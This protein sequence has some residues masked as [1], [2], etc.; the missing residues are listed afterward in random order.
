MKLPRRHVLPPISEKEFQA[1]V[2]ELARLFGFRVYH[3][4]DSRRSAK[5]FPDLV[6]V[7]PRDH[8]KGFARVIF[9][10]LKS[11]RGKL[12]GEQKEWIALLRQTILEVYIWRP[13]DW[14]K[15]QTILTA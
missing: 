1:Q 4:F 3:T 7:H 8:D 9:A 11:E 15:I 2:I 6:L 13:S 10:E 14:P 12:S 5:G